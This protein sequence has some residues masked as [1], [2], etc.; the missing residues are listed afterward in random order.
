MIFTLACTL[1]LHMKDILYVLDCGATMMTMMIPMVT[2]NTLH[3]IFYSHYYCDYNSERLIKMMLSEKSIGIQYVH[4]Q[5]KAYSSD[6]G[7]EPNLNYTRC[8]KGKNDLSDTTSVKVD[9]ETI[10]YFHQMKV[11]GRAACA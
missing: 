8:C 3:T 6:G 1:T 9:E 10:F 5:E 4:I 7:G 11:T 2:M